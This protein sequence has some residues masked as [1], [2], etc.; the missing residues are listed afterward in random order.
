MRARTILAMGLTTLLLA[1]SAAAA[2]QADAVGS[3]TRAAHTSTATTSTAAHYRAVQGA[4]AR[5]QAEEAS[6]LAAVTK[7]VH[8][9]EFTAGVPASQYS[10]VGLR[11]SGVW[12]T[13]TLRPVKGAELDPATV[14]LRQAKGRWSVV[15]LGTAEVG[16]EVA[17]ADV[18]GALGLDCG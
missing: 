6:T 5:R 13:V 9:S 7:A 14:L 16:C 2:G 12:A 15:D 3:V 4:H 17:P 8:A 1:G 11:T 10:V 18:V